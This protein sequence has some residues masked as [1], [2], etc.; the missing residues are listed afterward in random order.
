LPVAAVK[1]P[2][3]HELGEDLMKS[4]LH[5]ALL[6][7]LVLA[8]GLALG[9]NTND[10]GGG[11]LDA[12]DV[13][14]FFYC[15]TG[16]DVPA[17]EDCAVL[18]D[19]DGDLDVDLEDFAVL[20]VE[21]GYIA[22]VQIKQVTFMGSGFCAVKIDC[23][24]GSCSSYGTPH[25]LDTNLHGDTSDTGDHQFPVAYVRNSAITLSGVRFG[26]DPGDLGLTDVPVRGSGPDGIEF[27]GTAYTSGA[28][29]IVTGTMTSTTPL[30]NQVTYYEAFPIAWE[31]ALNGF[32]YQ[33]AGTSYHEIYVTY[34]DPLGE[35]LES[36]FDIATKAAHGQA[37]QQDIIDAIWEEFAD[38]EV[39]N[40][41]GERLGYYRGVLCASYCTYYTASQLVYYTTSQC[42]GWAN[43][44]MQCF[45]VQGIS[46][47]QFITAQP[48][49][50]GTLPVDC[51]SP[52]QPPSG[53]IVKNYTFLPGSSSGCAAYPFKF[54]DPC[55]YYTAWSDP[56][57]VDAPG[58][59]GQDNPN[60]AS[61]FA[62]HFIV[63]IN[64][65]YYDPS[66]GAGPFTGTTHQATMVWETGAIA[67]YQGKATS[68]RAGV[69][70]DS[71]QIRECYF[72][73]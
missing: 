32:T 23:P 63:K 1:N 29:L 20:Q 50:D 43:L 10:A 38:L 13:E 35:K 27:L 28:T 55:N 60:P 3:T 15:Q 59:P 44:L 68:S 54:N 47:A 46:G 4:P 45:S 16:P 14:D 22:D 66:Y 49:T 31:V 53:F 33:P 39:W 5:A 6:A 30:P 19:F 12:A 24:S 9:T 34:A 25:Y 71:A 2:D 48:R 42:G 21:Y 62:R 73:Q 40:A 18:Y 11:I 52:A 36:Y 26:T 70:Q 41:H 57:V 17:A 51:G 58:L 7:G 37:S 72:D 61:W 65:K 64:N 69:R 67:G 8:A 56:T